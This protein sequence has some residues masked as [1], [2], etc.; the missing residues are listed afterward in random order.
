[1]YYAGLLLSYHLERQDRIFT[2]RTHYIRWSLHTGNIEYEPEVFPGRVRRI[3]AP[4]IVFLLFSSGKIIIAG[5]TN[6][7]DVT[8]GVEIQRK[9]QYCRQ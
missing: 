7:D 8:K 3:S 2:I 9:T 1:M 5:E 4:K 6:V